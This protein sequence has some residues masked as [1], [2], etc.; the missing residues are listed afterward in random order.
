MV[1]T[2]KMANPTYDVVVPSGKKQ[3]SAFTYAGPPGVVV[4]AGALVRVP[5][6]TR[7]V[8][9]IVLGAG[10]VQLRA[11][12]P[13]KTVLTDSSLFPPFF[14]PLARAIAERWFTNFSTALTRSAPAP[15]WTLKKPMPDLP[16]FPTSSKS[17]FSLRLV[18]GSVQKRWEQY[19]TLLKAA[20]PNEKILVLLANQEL[21]REFCEGLHQ[22]GVVAWE[23][24]GIGGGTGSWRIARRGQFQ[25]LVGTRSALFCPY[26]LDLI[27]CDNPH[28]LGFVSERAPRLQIL[29]AV[30][31]RAKLEKNTL[32]IGSGILPYGIEGQTMDK[33]T[34]DRF[35]AATIIELKKAP[36][37]LST[38]AYIQ[39][40]LKAKQE[41]VVYHNRTGK[42]LHEV[43]VRCSAIRP[44]S[45]ATCGQCGGTQFKK[46]GFGVEE[47]A[48]LL[49]TELGLKPTIVAGAQ[50]NWPSG[51]QLVVGTRALFEHPF[52]ENSVAVMLDPD[53]LL[54]SP[55]Y[56]AT[57]ELLEDFG[58][59][60]GVNHIYIQ[61]RYPEHAVFKQWGAWNT[62][63]DT[64]LTHRKML[65]LPPYGRMVECRLLANPPATVHALAERAEQ[66]K[67]GVRI[68]QNSL[69]LR[70]KHQDVAQFLEKEKLPESDKWRIIPEPRRE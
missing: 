4:K 24:T 40:A 20:R 18:S 39:H 59:L 11:L 48:D 32:V 64:D 34:L 50:S 7:F 38:L 37:E 2:M 69:F 13:I 51:A 61:T 62:V 30:L 5:L 29:P 45:Q 60:R 68:E 42:T 33:T 53:S 66:A 36:F 1:H 31:A 17:S 10:S 12:K 16:A 6:G 70:G 56:T 19:R 41:V 35:P 67:L 58:E 44:I 65:Q 3:L 27:I 52:P 28:H 26:P 23:G 25:I 46:I 55:R 47:L 49:T 21:V 43:C 8:N 57:E 54:T 15:L 22:E 9:G 14:I 63:R